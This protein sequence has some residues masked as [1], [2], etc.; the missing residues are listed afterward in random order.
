MGLQICSQSL[1]GE[2]ARQ[3]CIA[4]SKPQHGENIVEGPVV[5]AKMNRAASVHVEKLYCLQQYFIFLRSPWPFRFRAR[6][7]STIVKAA[8]DSDAGAKLAKGLRNN[9]SAIS[10][11]NGLGKLHV[12]EIVQANMNVYRICNA[13]RQQ[14]PAPPIAMRSTPPQPATSPKLEARQLKSAIS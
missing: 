10:M 6:E 5:S 9:V 2:S 11:I 3:A 4:V 1:D 13:E 8:L 7:T 12:W 14:L